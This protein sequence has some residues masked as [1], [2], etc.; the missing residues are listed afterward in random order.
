MFRFASPE[1]L[2]LLILLPAFVGL[3]IYLSIRNRK[4]LAL[5]ASDDMLDYLMPMRSN[6]RKKLKFYLLLSAL[7]IAIFILARPQFG[8]KLETVKRKGVEVIVAMDVSNSM[9]AEDISPNR[10]VKAKRIVSKLID[11]LEDDKIG[12]IVFA[13][14]AYT[15]IPITSDFISAKMFMP[16]ISPNLVPVQGTAIGAAIEMGIHS[17]NPQG[18]GKVGRSIIVITDGENHEDNAVDAAKEALKQGITVNVIGMGRPEG[19][20]IPIPGT[21]SYKKDN[22]GTV[23]VTKLNEQMCEEIAQAGGGIYV[24]ADNGNGAQKLIQQQIDNMAKSEVET[25]LFSEYSDQ[26]QLFAGLM[27]LLLV[28]ELLI[29]ESKNKWL[30]KIKLFE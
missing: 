18:K 12:L 9:M 6:R 16:S 29:M 25:Q 15:Q 3:F 21:S 13:G 19:A 26:F 7:T 17:F 5:L 2:Y 22:T 24:R 4:N 23:V 11:N 1:Y 30:N 27:F 10:L 14:D 8:S 28:V 20:P